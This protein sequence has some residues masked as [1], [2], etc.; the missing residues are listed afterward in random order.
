MYPNEE[1]PIWQVISLK[2]VTLWFL[3][4][5]QGYFQKNSLNALSLVLHLA[6]TL[7]YLEVC[8]SISEVTGGKVD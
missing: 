6:Y 5:H 3:I 8:I 7:F 4:T 1:D 2:G